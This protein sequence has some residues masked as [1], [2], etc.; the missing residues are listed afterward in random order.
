MAYH[1]R[2]FCITEPQSRWIDAEA[3][4]SGE[5]GNA[6]VRKVLDK[7]IEQLR[8]TPPAPHSSA[9]QKPTAAR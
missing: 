7:H 4:R 2:Q 3:E 6:V 8:N 5:T 9:P 1:R